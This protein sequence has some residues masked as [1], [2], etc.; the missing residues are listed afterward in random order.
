MYEDW[1]A[2]VLQNAAMYIYFPFSVAVWK[3]LGLKFTWLGLE[4]NNDLD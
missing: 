3:G 4:R 1:T 2:E